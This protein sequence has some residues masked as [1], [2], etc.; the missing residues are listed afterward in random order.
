MDLTKAITYR[1]F[2]LNSLTKDANQNLVGCEVTQVEYPGV[3]GV[4]YDEKRAL[5]D[6]YDASDVFLGKRLIGLTG[7]LYGTTR[8]EFFD[9]KQALVSAMT[10]T[11]AY[12][13]S[14]GD[15]GFLPF[16][17]YEPTE[18]LVDFPLGYI[19]KMVFARPVRQPSLILASDATG[20]ADGQPLSLKWTGLLE[21]KDPRVYFFTP[22][23]VDLYGSISPGSGNLVN[24]GNYPSP[25]HILLVIPPSPAGSFHFVGAGTDLTITLMTSEW[26][27]VYRYDSGLKILTWEQQGVESL[28][29]DLL[30]LASQQSHPLVPVGT[31]AYTWTMPGI[32]TIGYGSRF[33]HWDAWA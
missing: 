12:A 9:L 18:N 11:S 20:G 25:L 16:D 7:A 28:R 10:P 17:Y 15:K 2:S 33:W 27:Q 19:H 1:T 24:H 26:E 14:P 31:S 29:M 8:G 4:G 32:P 22:T 13:Q 6:G 30:T 3:P 23:I 21:C 5:A